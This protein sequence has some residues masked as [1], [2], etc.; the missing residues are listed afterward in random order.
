MD[1][2]GRVRQCRRIRAEG[3]TVGP[4]SL[5]YIGFESQSLQRPLGNAE[6]P[7]VVAYHIEMTCT[8]SHVSLSRSYTSP[9]PM[10]KTSAKYDYL[11]GCTVLGAGHQQVQGTSFAK[12]T[13]VHAKQFCDLE[14]RCMLYQNP[15]ERKPELGYASCLFQMWLSSHS[16]PSHTSSFQ[17]GW[18]AS[19]DCFLSVNLACLSLT[20]HSLQYHRVCSSNGML[21]PTSSQDLSQRDGEIN[22]VPSTHTVQIFCRRVDCVSPC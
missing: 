20:F 16:G 3:R 14:R 15:L 22:L 17:A 9:E 10:R 5:P 21:E 18:L 8:S 2:G 4:S 19:D 7:W 1:A 13:L 12:R 6:D 11:I